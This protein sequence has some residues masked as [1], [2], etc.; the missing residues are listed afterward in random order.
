MIKRIEGSRYDKSIEQPIKPK[1]ELEFLESIQPKYCWE[2][3][4]SRDKWDKRW[5]KT[6]FCSLKCWANFN[7]KRFKPHKEYCGSL[8]HHRDYQ[9]DRDEGIITHI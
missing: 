8:G 4:A 9:F 1:N 2:C 7:A 5:K 6:H 3:E